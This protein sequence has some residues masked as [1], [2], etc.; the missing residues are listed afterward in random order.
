MYQQSVR[1]MLLAAGLG[2]AA[3]AASGQDRPWQKLFGGPAP[4]VA[5]AKLAAEQARRLAE[6]RVELAWL[7]DPITFPYFLDAKTEGPNLKVRGFVPDNAVRAQAMK[8]AQVYSAYPVVDTLKEHPALLVRPGKIAPQQLHSAVVAALREALPRQYQR[9]Q[10][11]CAADGTVVLR[12]QL[13]SS[14]EKLAAALALR[15]LYGCTSV[16][17]AIQVPGVPADVPPTAVARTNEPPAVAPA[18][19]PKPAVVAQ[20]PPKPA[21]TVEP[22]EDDEPPQARFGAP[23]PVKGR[24]KPAKARPKAAA[25]KT[26]EPKVA[27]APQK[28]AEDRPSAKIVGAIPTSEMPPPPRLGDIE[29]PPAPDDKAPAGPGLSP[30]PTVEP[31]LPGGAAAKQPA[32][33]RKLS[34]ADLP[35]L[36]KRVTDACPGAKGVKLELMT[37]NKLKIE[38][39][40]R[41]E[42]QIGTFTGSIFNIGELD[43]YR[44]DIELHFVL[45]ESPARK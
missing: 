43:D 22:D 21:P 36:Q 10:V 37:G 26:A 4:K 35:R 3:G 34:P 24:T 16:Q 33:A 2:L 27:E 5:A 19:A 25:P 31:P 13:P 11:Q 30:P 9:V 23:R 28:P 18:P 14:E 44:E 40:V 1:G 7:A 12:G 32:P 15:R 29:N 38:L 17:T 42:A 20:A 39:T 41:S 8:L 45:S 6:I